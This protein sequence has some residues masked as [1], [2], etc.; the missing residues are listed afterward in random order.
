M[1]EKIDETINTYNNIVNEYIE[2]FN[3][4]DMH[5]N[6]QFQKEIDILIDNLETGSKILDVGTA[7]GDYPKYLTEKC[8]KKF[9][10]IGIDSSENMI[11]V[12]KQ[13]APKANF[14]VMDMRYLDFPNDYFDAIICLATLIHVNDETAIEVMQKFDS[15][16]K[17]KGIMVINVMEYIN[18]KKEKYIKEPFN[19]KFNTYFNTYS[20]DFFINWFSKNN[21]SI[22]GI[23]DN[24]VFNSEVVKEPTKDTNQFSIIVKK[25]KGVDP[26]EWK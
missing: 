26:N 15:I 16:L 19:P 12:A 7:I 23:I 3:T 8:N 13:K 9:E 6:V 10:V 24:P 4:K 11:K 21:Y 1:K 14:K 25:E 5:G 2:Y 20:K 18:G 17:E 22:L